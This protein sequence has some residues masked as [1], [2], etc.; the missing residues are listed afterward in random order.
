MFAEMILAGG[1]IRTLGR[2]G[3]NP[4]SHLAIAGGKVF[5]CGGPE[6]MKLR[7]PRTKVVEL[8]GSAVL[9]G[10][11]D[12]HA[13]VVYY[14]L[15]RFAADLGGARGV[16]DILD[17]LRDHG[18]SLKPGEWQQGMGYRTDELTERRQPHRT[19]LDRVTGERPAFIDERGGHSRIA[20]SAALAAA[21]ITPETPNPPGGRIG[22][23]LNRIPNGLL[24][25]SAMRLV[26][27]VQPLPGLARRI[28]GVLK[29]QD[30]LVSRGITSV[31]AAVNRGFADDLRAYEQLARDGKLRIRVNEF[32]SWELLE[33]TSQLGVQSGFGGSL[34]RAGPIK[35][36]VDGQVAAHAIGD[37]AIE[38]MCDAVEGAHGEHMRH[39]V[40]HCTICPPD[41]QARL[42]Q[43][44]M[45]AIMQPMAARFG[46]VA[47]TIFFP[48]RDRSHL[49]PHRGLLRAK[50]P[51]AFSSDLPVSP[52][53]N[54][55]PGIRVAVDDQV[56]GISLL[57]ALRA[58]I[59]GGAYATFEENVKGT[60]EPGMLADLQVY[61]GDPLDEAAEVKWDELRPRAV[62]LGGEVVSGSLRS[63]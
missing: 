53:P 4:H 9:P 63:R 8:K 33:S 27:D 21:G 22:R 45:V 52:D 60:L 43:L 28:E 37:A 23:D 17:R 41:L 51:L 50:V 30:L 38:A 34:V 18:R 32:L 12:A 62:V 10:F 7:G 40:E 19:E 35:V 39:R 58:Y 3:L 1:R 25:E 11:N 42:G 6:V 29:A 36:F 54:P 20:N 57:A 14:G 56:N 24:L 5:A 46:R 26:A 47:S 48:V 16:D 44:G 49:A 55:W 13:H 2:T 61:S 59:S 15:T 31:G